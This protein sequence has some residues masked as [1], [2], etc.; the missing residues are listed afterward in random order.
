MDVNQIYVIVTFPLYMCRLCQYFNFCSRQPLYKT[1]GVN[2]ASFDSSP[3]ATVQFPIFRRP[4]N[5]TADVPTF[6]AANTL[7]SLKEQVQK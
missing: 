4:N 7:A 6:E 2:G 3:N 5:N 1:F